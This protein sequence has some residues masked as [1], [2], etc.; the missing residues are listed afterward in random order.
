MPTHMSLCC[1]LGTRTLIVTMH[2]NF[3]SFKP[4]DSNLRFKDNSL[5]LRVNKFKHKA[6][7]LRLK[8]SQDKKL[9]AWMMK[10]LS[11]G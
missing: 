4:T 9:P 11:T 8:G 7:R 6:L 2:N 1:I 3:S 5:W 10:S